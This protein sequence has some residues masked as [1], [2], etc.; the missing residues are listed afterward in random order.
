MTE[1]SVYFNKRTPR[2]ARLFN[3]LHVPLL[4]VL[5]CMHFLWLQHWYVSRFLNV[6]SERHV[7]SYSG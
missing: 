6:L 7:H 3:W 2:F 5:Q 1:Y 4:C